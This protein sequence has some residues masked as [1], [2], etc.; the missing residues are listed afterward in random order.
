LTPHWAGWEGP[1]LCPPTEALVAALAE[2][3][4]TWA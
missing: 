4:Q 2:A 1:G 3:A